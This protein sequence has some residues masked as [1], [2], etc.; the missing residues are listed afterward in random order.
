MLHSMIVRS[1]AV[2][3]SAF[4]FSPSCDLRVAMA[5]SPCRRNA[6]DCSDAEFQNEDDWNL[7]PTAELLPVGEEF[8]SETSLP[9]SD[10]GVVKSA[11]AMGP[12]QEVEEEVGATPPELPCSPSEDEVEPT[13]DEAPE[14][15]SKLNQ[16]R[17]SLPPEPVKRMRLFKKPRCHLMCSRRLREIQRRCSCRRSTRRIFSRSTSGPS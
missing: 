7:E 1:A 16:L 4:V 2:W 3:E 5:D 8:L 6:W 13:A 14:S 17:L 11:E 15:I 12:A 10:V 9:G